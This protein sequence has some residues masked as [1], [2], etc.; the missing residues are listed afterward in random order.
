MRTHIY[1]ITPPKSALPSKTPNHR[2]INQASSS[3]IR[4][5]YYKGLRALMANLGDDASI[6][7]GMATSMQT[8]GIPH[9]HFTDPTD[10]VFCKGVLLEGEVAAV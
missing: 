8:H 2:I 1:L 3:Q 9:D 5:F 6:T 10:E 4:L 7:E